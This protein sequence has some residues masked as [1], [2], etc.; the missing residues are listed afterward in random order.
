M[1]INVDVFASATTKLGRDVIF[2][3]NNVSDVTYQSE[4][5][6]THVSL[7]RGVTYIFEGRT[8]YDEFEKCLIISPYVR[9]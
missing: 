7:I 6:E 8:L 4:L 2:N 1:N 9:K 3:L 5:D